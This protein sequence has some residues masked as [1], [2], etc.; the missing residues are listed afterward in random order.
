MGRIK[1][2]LRNT[3][4]RIKS[5]LQGRTDT[6]YHIATDANGC[7]II[8]LTMGNETG[9][10]SFRWDAV[11]MVRTFK[12]DQ[13]AVDC[14]CMA[15]ETP[16]GWIEVNEDMKSFGPFL[17]AVE[18]CLPGFPPQEQWWHQVMLPAFALNEK[19]LWKRNKSEPNR[20]LA[21]D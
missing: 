19:D 15:F 3:R 9:E 4:E 21:T 6:V 11:T 10:V 20:V 18:R 12:R 13:L 2:F 5:R 17:E 16:D 14:I 8:W 7:R 1:K